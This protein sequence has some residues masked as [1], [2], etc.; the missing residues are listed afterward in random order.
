MRL[1]LNARDEIREAPLSGFHWRLAFLFFFIML[2]DGYDLFNAAYVIPLVAKTWQPSSIAIGMMLSSGIVGLSVG[3]VLQGLL[4]DRIGRRKVMLIALMLLSAASLTLATLASSP[5]SFAAFRLVLGTALGMVTPLTL[6]YVNEWAPRKHAN[7]YAT[8]V[9]QI[10]FSAGGIAA[11]LAGVTLTGV[12]RWQSI[13]V[14]GVA[15]FLVAIAAIFWLPESVQYLALHRNFSEVRRLL[16]KVRPDRLDLYKEAEFEVVQPSAAAGSITVLL[17]PLY[18]R[19]TLVGWAAGFLSLFCIHGLTGWLPTILIGRGEAVSSGFAYGSLIMMASAFGGVTSGWF[20]DKI[21]SRIRAM[22]VW[23][24]LAA[25]AIIGLGLSSN[26]A[27]TMAFV[28]AAGFFVFGAQAVMNNFQAMTYRTEVRSTGVG[29]AVGLNRVGG[30]LGPFLI[31]VLHSLH[32]DPLYTFLGLVVAMGTAAVLVCL[33]RTE[34]TCVPT[35][36]VEPQ[37]T[38]EMTGTVR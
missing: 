11:G 30:I 10:G 14:V 19:N 12:F 5:L 4:A 2:F 9:F 3:S 25:T 34:I 8:W 29:V 35:R 7:A 37:P 16:G 33:A 6:T 18:R 15:S 28:V 17:S 20:A 13:Y 31:G 26:T 38:L 1:V 27:S 24:L 21:R 23:Y 32:P 22:I 36:V